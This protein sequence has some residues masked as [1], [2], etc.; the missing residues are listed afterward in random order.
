MQRKVG[1]NER[2]KEIPHKKM[3]YFL[4]TSRLQRL[5]VSKTIAEHIRWHAKSK[6]ENGYICHPH[7]NEA[8]QHFDKNHPNFAK[9]VQNIRLGLCTDRFSPFGLSG[10]QYSS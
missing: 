5:Y 9:E 10:K 2:C 1:N 8:W 6:P 4:I 3:Y 7:D